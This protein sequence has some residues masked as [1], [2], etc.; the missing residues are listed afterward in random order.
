MVHQKENNDWSSDEKNQEIALITAWPS[1][2]GL[3]KFAIFREPNATGGHYKESGLI[4][5]P[6]FRH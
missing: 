2:V 5:I 1:A 6:G 3:G 4:V